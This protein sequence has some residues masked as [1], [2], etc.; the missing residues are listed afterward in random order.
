MELSFFPKPISFLQYALPEAQEAALPK[1][2]GYYLLIADEWNASLPR[3]MAITGA[4]TFLSLDTAHIYSSCTVRVR[5]VPSSSSL[6]KGNPASF[7]KPWE[8][9]ARRLRSSES[10]S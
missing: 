9:G 1:H 5:V 4:S 10:S 3:S 8:Q 2:Q 6:D 7:L